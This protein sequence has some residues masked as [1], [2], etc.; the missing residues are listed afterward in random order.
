MKNSILFRV[1]VLAGA[2]LLVSSGWGF[3]ANADSEIKGAD[4]KISKTTDSDPGG[5][6]TVEGQLSIGSVD[7]AST[8]V[9]A[10]IDIASS[11]D[12]DKLPTV[13]AVR[14]LKVPAFCASKEDNPANTSNSSTVPFIA[15]AEKFDTTNSYDNAT[16]KFTAP[17]AGI[18]HFTW[19]T[20][21][22]SDGRTGL[23]VD[24]V[25][26]TQ[27][28]YSSGHSLSTLVNLSSE[29]KVHLAGVNTSSLMKSY[30]GAGANMFCG[31]L[32]HR[33]D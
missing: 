8:G 10:S 16:G 22:S 19:T 1:W 31:H 9:A 20:F 14:K 28:S 23:W 27:V 30:G 6:L 17:Y 4:L 5:D 25:L 29:S 26:Y 2:M 24:D 15:N 18:Y 12:D 32:V 11:S 3:E 7:T 13:I 21:S 33:T